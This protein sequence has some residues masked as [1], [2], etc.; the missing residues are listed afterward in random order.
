M[1]D[2][3]LQLKT[4]PPRLGRGIASRA[5]LDRRWAEVGDRTAIVVTAPQG[6]GKTTLLAQWRRHWLEQ[7]ALVA[8]ASLDAQDDRARFVDLLFFALRAATGRESFVTAAAQGRLQSNREL[9]ALTTLLAEIAGLATPTV[10]IL[11]DA[12]R[13]PQDTLREVLAYLLN[14]AP[15]NLQCLIGT[16]RPLEV[17]LSDLVAGGR[18]AAVNVGELRLSLDESLEILRA[19]FGN[20]IGLDDA[21]HLHDLMEGWPLGLQLAVSSLERATDMGGM[22]GHLTARRG[23]LQRFFL[24]S[25]MARLP[26]EESAFLVRIAILEAVNADLCEAVTGCREAARFLDSLADVSPLVTVGEDRDWMRLHSMARDFLLGQF[27]RLPAEE[28]RAC[29]ERAAAWYAA[30]GQLQEAARHAL[31]AGDE[32][33]AVTLAAQCL[34]DIAREGRLAEANDWIKRLPASVMTRD[35]RLQVTVAWVTALG[36]GAASVPALIAQL[37]RH[38]EL[39]EPC[40]FDAA[41]AL[42]ASAVFCDQPGRVADALQSWEQAP[43]TVEPMRVAA[44]ATSKAALALH[45]GDN[46]RVRRLLSDCTA[47]A[48][49]DPSMR[50]ALGFADLLVGLSHFM[51]GNA[52]R[53]IALLQPRL[54]LAEREMG[55]RSVVAGMLAGALATAQMT[56]GAAEAALATLADRL[57]VI[58]RVGMPDPTMLAYRTLAAIALRRGEEA[59]ALEYLTALHEF[60]AARDLPRVRFVSLAEQIRLHAMRGRTG[61][62]SELLAELDA[63]RSVIEQPEYRPFLWYFER[64]RAVASAYASLAKGDLESSAATLRETL[65]ATAGARR[66]PLMLMARALLAL[67][68]HEQGHA[69]ARAMLAEVLDLAELGGIRPLIET[70][71]PRLADLMAQQGGPA[72]TA[73][74][75]AAEAVASARP[76]S[77][78]VPPATAGGLLTPKE[79]RILSLLAVGKANKEIA[80]A[81]DIGEQ[82]VKWH[83][84]NVFFKLDAASRKHAVD[85]AR[86]LGLLE[87]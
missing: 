39:D 35:V 50:L 18:L 68:A 67:I 52:N 63:L 13:M 62:A 65:H 19:R 49:R 78:S 81:M 34:F 7:G 76:A 72:E 84:K 24:E 22:I 57:D 29:Y 15:P 20:R 3:R 51:D 54:A 64:S 6:F 45:L 5:R 33:L 41:L 42:S 61:T 44:L 83:L 71:H 12:H 70:T 37:L 30:H 79:A 9:E 58:E 23:D 21:V 82:T 73:P 36:S 47:S 4:A 40:R 69:E 74:V 48:P 10:I 14:N 43:D 28:R 27:D 59:Q 1:P 85:R 32:T 75:R 87:G 26:P 11:D 66:G 80:R 2:A 77:A 46:E 86:L 16:R 38:P 53:A 31:A 55:R 56:T 17:D 8:W 60:G 25:V